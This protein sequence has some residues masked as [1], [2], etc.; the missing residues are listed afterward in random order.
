MQAIYHLNPKVSLC[1]GDSTICI[2]HSKIKS[3]NRCFFVCI[4]Q[5]GLVYRFCSEDGK[6]AQKNTSECEDDPGEVCVHSAVLCFCV[7]LSC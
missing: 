1:L 3:Y 5:D 4:V 2:C 6:W 7:W